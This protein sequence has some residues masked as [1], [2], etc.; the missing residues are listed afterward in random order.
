MIHLLVIMQTYNCKNIL[1]LVRWENNSS[2]IY[3]L[4]TLS[5]TCN[6]SCFQEHSFWSNL[7]NRIFFFSKKTVLTDG[8]QN[9]MTSSW[10]GI[11]HMALE[12]STRAQTVT[13]IF[14]T[15]DR[16]INAVP[17]LPSGGTMWLPK[18]PQC[19]ERRELAL[20]LVPKNK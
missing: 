10:Q 12:Q 3:M 18:C 8:Y 6:G 11:I 1:V 14:N 17:L 5:F 2:F 13:H 9:I 7:F 19:V 15:K 4:I 16:K 20:L